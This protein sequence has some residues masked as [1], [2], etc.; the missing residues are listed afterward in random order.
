MQ[1]KPTLN[2]LTRRKSINSRPLEQRR[3]TDIVVS[4]DL[5][6]QI[7]RRIMSGV[8]HIMIG[9]ANGGRVL[10]PE[11]LDVEP[12]RE[13]RL[14][15]H[16]NVLPIRASDVGVEVDSPT[17]VQDLVVT[18]GVDDLR[19][20]IRTI[21]MASEL[22]LYMRP[23]ILQLLSN[24]RGIEALCHFG[25]EFPI[26]NEFKQKFGF[27]VGERFKV[28]H[29]FG[30]EGVEAI[31]DLSK[32]E[33]HVARS[34]WMRK[35]V[36]RMIEDMLRAEVLG[37][38]SEWDLYGKDEKFG[39]GEFEEIDQE[40]IDMSIGVANPWRFADGGLLN[41]RITFNGA[42]AGFNLGEREFRAR[43]K[44]VSGGGM[45]EERTENR[46]LAM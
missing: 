42:H 3:A 35:A 16:S 46:S 22:C 45:V 5:Y 1:F 25:V 9:T 29:I 44:G 36:L 30:R 21:D 15:V 33:G 38:L 13:D 26:P 40:F 2:S 43:K 32:M 41:L 17:M 23:Y 37:V 6:L 24:S 27:V 28:E 18:Q 12:A 10:E 4:D 8:N 19:D 7:R 31:D 11:D 14:L 34:R 20:S 39:T